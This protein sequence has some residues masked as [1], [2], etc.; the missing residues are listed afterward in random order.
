MPFH[1]NLATKMHKVNRTTLEVLPLQE[2]S[3]DFYIWFHWRF[4]YE[5]ILLILYPSTNGQK[6]STFNQ[7]I[8]KKILGKRFYTCSGPLAGI[9]TRFVPHISFS[10][11][12]YWWAK[13]EY[14]S[15]STPTTYSNKCKQCTCFSGN[16]ILTSLIFCAGLQNN[17]RKTMAKSWRLPLLAGVEG[18]TIKL[19]GVFSYSHIILLWMYYPEKAHKLRKRERKKKAPVPNERFTDLYIALL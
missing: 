18:R 15:R 16:A 3:T 13:I 10:S 8:N 17:S 11:W 5:I 19:G 9:C 4:H 2:N 12:F 14:T 7:N 6:W 1:R